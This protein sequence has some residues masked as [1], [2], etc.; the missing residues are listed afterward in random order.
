MYNSYEEYMQRVLGY[1]VPNTYNQTDEY[2][3]MPQINLE[4]QEINNLYPEIYRIVYPIIQKACSVRRFTNITEKQ[5]EEIVDEVY[6]VVEPEETSEVETNL[7]NGDVRNPRNK[8]TRNRPSRKN[9][10]L[11]DLIKI[12]VLKEILGIDRQRRIMTR[13]DILPMQSE[14]R[15]RIP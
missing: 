6:S 13:Y 9:Q 5:I 11:R 12:L 1:N 10:L 14:T 7:K 2:Y 8:E 15:F 4:L 3:G